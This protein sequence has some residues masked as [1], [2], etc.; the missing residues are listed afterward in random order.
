MI[1]PPLIMFPVD[2]MF[3]HHNQINIFD[4]PGILWQRNLASFF[5]N[6]QNTPSEL[7]ASHADNFQYF[8]AKSSV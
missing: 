2:W 3:R 5:W 6:T 7:L 4:F 8:N 1:Y